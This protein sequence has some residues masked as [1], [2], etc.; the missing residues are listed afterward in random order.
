MLIKRKKESAVMYYTM[1]QAV[2]NPYI[3]YAFYNSKKVCGI[4]ALFY[5]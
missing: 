1:K 3:V 5:S 2:K 4:Q